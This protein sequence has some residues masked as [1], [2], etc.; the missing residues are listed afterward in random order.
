[1]SIISQDNRSRSTCFQAV[2]SGS[3]QAMSIISQDNRSRSTCFQ[4]VSS[5]S[6]QAMSI[7]VRGRTKLCL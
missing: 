2:S 1:M 6:D 4:A 3:D 7:I 5:G